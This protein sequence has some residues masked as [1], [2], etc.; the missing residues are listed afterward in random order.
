[1]INGFPN[2]YWGWGGEDDALGFRLRA[3]RVEIA[4]PSPAC[5]NKI[6]DLEEE[7][8][9]NYCGRHLRDDHLLMCRDDNPGARAGASLKEGGTSFFRNNLRQE[10][11]PHNRETWT[12]K[13]FNDCSY[14]IEAEITTV[15]GL[16]P[17]DGTWKIY[18]V[19][20]DPS[21]SGQWAQKM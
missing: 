10:L 8:P 7:I 12:V 16:P 6:R 9:G 13:G 19:D 20:L 17:S 1:M 18:K 15:P 5:D 3:C 14:S 2:D 21:S 4:L 11:A